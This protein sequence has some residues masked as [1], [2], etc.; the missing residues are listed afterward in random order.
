MG[1]SGL[2]E[3]N[4]GRTR[5]DIIQAALGLFEER[6]YDATRCEDIA[7]AADVSVRTFFRYF[8]TKV[9]V[10]MATTGDERP[11]ETFIADLL[12]RPSTEGP[13][14]AFGNMMRAPIAVFESGR[15]LE[16]RQ[17]LLMLTTPGLESLLLEHFRRIESVL[18]GA[19]ATRLNLPTDD[20]D[21]WLLAAAL[22]AA[23]RIAF[24]HWANSGAPPGTLWP[25]LQ[26]RLDR[27]EHGFAELRPA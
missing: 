3:R 12:S 1:R 23:M 22:C 2:R 4:K 7:A 24:V 19:I 26:E 9:D 21:A 14:T 27:L 20:L 8:D 11:D 13:V 6:G 16:V 15:T 25:L 18:V 5:D 17:T 10:V